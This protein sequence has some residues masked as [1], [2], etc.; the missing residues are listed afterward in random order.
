MLDVRAPLAVKIIDANPHAYEKLVVEGGTP[1]LAHEMLDGVQPEQL[2]S[3]PTASPVA[4]FAMLAGLWLWHDGLDECHKIAQKSPEE[5]HHSALNLHSKAPEMCENGGSMQSMENSKTINHLELQQMTSTLSF[6]HAIM[7]RR[8]GDFSNSKYWYARAAGH[9]SLPSLAAAAADLVKRAPADKALLR[10][11]MSG[12]NANAF[13]DLVEA[14]EGNEADNRRDIAVQLQKLEWNI[15]FE[16]CAR[17][18]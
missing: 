4:A 2:L 9:P 3:R 8:E 18:G 16:S 6:W 11:I 17:A 13:V 15:L 7:H 14:V 10:L 1:A 12:W 5:L